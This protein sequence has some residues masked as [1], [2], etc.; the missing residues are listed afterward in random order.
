MARSSRLLDLLDAL[1]RHR[2]PVTG[3][4]LAAELGTS[5][6]T[7]YRDVASLRAL[8]A[9]ID[10]EPGLGY[11]L[12]PGF[13]LPP[14]MFPPDEIEALVLGS[15][16]VANNG[17]PRL[18]QAARMALAR[19][20]AVLPTAARDGMDAT[21]L[22]VGPAAPL[23]SGPVDVGQVRAAIRDERKLALS[24]RDGDGV[25]TT[26]TV[27]PIALAFFDQ[28]RVLVAWCELR[29][30]FRHFRVDRIETARIVDQRPPRRRAALIRAWRAAQ[31]I[32]DAGA[33]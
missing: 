17:D 2:R 3:A 15:R 25:A 6:R 29:G 27:W 32:A 5:L 9:A 18:A 14:L 33:G 26:R 12:R 23:P 10:G 22:W 24:Y 16:W 7:L 31:G 28:A 30:D 11:V 13:L 8:G 1:R 4:T 20:G 19:I 21:G